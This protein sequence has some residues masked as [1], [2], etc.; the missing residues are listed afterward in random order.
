MNANE[1]V[2]YITLGFTLLCFI[3]WLWQS[4]VKRRKL[5]DKIEEC[6]DA[7]QPDADVPATAAEKP[8]KK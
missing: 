3:V 1:A 8:E 2:M 4:I 6:R 7:N 5:E